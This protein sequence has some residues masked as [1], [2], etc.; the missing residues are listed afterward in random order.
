MNYLSKEKRLKLV[1]KALV[2]T[3]VMGMGVGVNTYYNKPI[4]AMAAET[5]SA[6]TVS[7]LIYTVS[8]TNATV[9]GTTLTTGDLVIPETV[10]INGVTCNVTS[11]G[12][13]A[14]RNCAGLTSV[15][16]PNSVTST[17]ISSF[18]NC[19]GLTSVIIPD[20]VTAIGAWSFQNCTGLTSVTIPNSVISIGPWAFDRCS[21]LTSVTI[22][23]S[24]TSIRF[25]AF[26]GCT[27]LTSVTIP[28]SVT[29]IETYAFQYCTGLTSVTI[30]NSVTSIGYKVFDGCTNLINV[31]AAYQLS[32]FST[33]NN[34][35]YS[36]SGTEAKVVN[37]IGVYGDLV[38]PSTV[39]I[40]GTSYNVTSIGTI[41]FTNCTGLTSVTI[42]NSVTSIELSAFAGCTGLTSVTIPSSVTSIGINAFANTGLISVIIPNSVTSIE[43]IA[44]NGCTRLTS[45]TIPDSV[46]SIE[47]S[48]FNGCPGLTSVKLNN[49]SQLDLFASANTTYHKVKFVDK[50]RNDLGDYAVLNGTDISS[51][52]I[53][54]TLS[55]GT[56]TSWET[57]SSQLTSI[58]SDT[59][60][61]ALSD[62]DLSDA[63]AAVVKAEQTKLQSDVDAATT[64]LTYVLDGT[65]KTALE[66]RLS[67][68]Q[69]YITTSAA[70]V[71]SV[72]S[73][74]D[75][76]VDNGTSV[77]DINLPSTLDVTLGNNTTT[78]AAVTWDTSSYD[79]DVA[80]TYIFTGALT[81][82]NGIINPNNLIASVNVIV[83]AK[84]ANTTTGAAVTVTTPSAVTIE[85]TPKVGET[86]TA[87]L[88]D[89]DGNSTTTSAAVTYNWYRL[90]N[91]NS[92]F[93]NI[94]AT[95]KKYIETAEDL[96]KYIGV[97]V[98][99]LGHHFYD[100]IG[101]VLGTSTS[102]DNGQTGG[103]DTNNDSTALDTAYNLIKAKLDTITYTNNITKDNVISSLKTLT[104][105]TGISV[106]VADSKLVQ[107]TYSNT[108]TDTLTITVT[109]NGKS[110]DYTYVG[111]IAKLVSS[112]S[113]SHSSGSSGS[114]GSSSSSSTS[115]TSG[116]TTSGSSTG[117]ATTA[118]VTKDSIAAA[119]ATI[120]V[121]NIVDSTVAKE[122]AQV[123]TTNIVSSLNSTVGKG[124]T[125]SVAKEVTTTDG[126][127]VKVATLTKDGTSLG[128]VITADK[129]SVTS[130]IPVDTST[131]NI[132]A[133]YK[134]VPLL[135]KYIQI[136]DGVTIGTNEVTLP[137]QAN[138]TYVA[139]ANKLA[140]TDTV[141][142][143]WAQINNN[144]YMVNKTGDLQTG[145]QND[146]NGW[147][148]MDTKTAAMKTGWLKDSSENWYYL[149]SN[150]YMATGWLKDSSE[151]WYYLNSDGSM[152][153]NTT[154]DGYNLDESGKLA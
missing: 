48:A 71:F 5:T 53:N 75:I 126:N 26:Y 89:E 138:T 140:S 55:Y 110:K 33:V 15:T 8:G 70:A 68:V 65:D 81:L 115:S 149:K 103:S 118:N 113:S 141:A 44:F 102:P 135:G 41:A 18:E 142:Q 42:P 114:S 57:D 32:A 19:T 82:P 12:D 117:T 146:N 80:G 151:N 111:N 64:A 78:T 87:Q 107:A 144:W 72:P 100:V 79:G 137:T 22:P 47:S 145:W 14:F 154:I 88:L 132:T 20:S 123:V 39:D 112:S 58:T 97:K 45:V 60:F 7:N 62:S 24:V 10:V 127:T 124:V 35:T 30:P 134:F 152:A 125:A 150:G 23:D 29:N 2:V 128:A 122:I 31:P 17:G 40:N 136:T 77:S 139:V 1:A 95:G 21:G 43:L 90:D 61:T 131:G 93:D 50:L 133:V 109:E 96:G 92:T 54:P 104:L 51:L 73:V 34:L 83:A 4:T 6:T 130:T 66:A 46:T 27:G 3:S 91:E 98:S 121:N 69:T 84:K 86:L 116:T 67:A 25:R 101:K 63:T 74:D 148:Y 94:I 52:I 147:T 37:A 153:S 38:I 56:F 143:G 119:I 36:I 85:G 76:N 16:I 11:I 28:N 9:V 49:A 105:P 106:S 108:G 99:Y 120:G 129:A 13:S 59:T